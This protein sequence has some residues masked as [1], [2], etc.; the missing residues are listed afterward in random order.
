MKNLNLYKSAICC[1]LL[2]F[3]YQIG[4]AQSNVGI[5]TLNPDPSSVLELQSQDKG[6]LI[7][8]MDSTLRIAIPN[9]ATGLLVYD[10]DYQSFFYFDGSQWVQ[11]I[12]PEG[13]TGPQGAQGIQGIQ[14]PTGS[15]G[16]QGPIGADGADGAT[17][18]Q[19]IQGPTGAQG[20]RGPAGAV[21]PQ[22]AQG[23]QGPQGL[24][25]LQG[26]QGIQGPQGPAG[27]GHIEYVQ[28]NRFFPQADRMTITSK[29]I[30]VT[31]GSKVLILAHFN[32]YISYSSYIAMRVYRN[33][34]K[35][36]VA[37]QYCGANADNNIFLQ[38]VD[39]PPAGTNTYRVTLFWY[40]GTITTY[41]YSLDLLE[42][43]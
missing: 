32:G 37:S 18:A 41:S 22:G 19:G 25:G 28:R 29:S 17:G 23:A 10:T 8:R 2:C 39:S 16:I 6:L 38:W 11:A 42:V 40:S 12:G 7:T 43:R 33:G 26:A 9:P 34:T 35:I 21:G 1:V 27:T 3:V 5:G 15:Q 31:S 20:I 24:R 30:N 36:H 13:P 14:G 4:K